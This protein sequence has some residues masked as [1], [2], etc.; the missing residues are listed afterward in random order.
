MTSVEGRHNT[1]TIPEEIFS[2]EEFVNS[3]SHGVA[4]GMSMAG[5]ALMIVVA[6][7][8]GG[9]IEIVSAVVYGTTLVMLFGAS[10]LYHGMRTPALK[11]TFRVVDHSA[12]YLLIAG[13]YTPL[14]LVTLSGE[15]GWVIFGGVWAMALIGVFY[16]IFW[17][18][19]FKGLGLG[20]YLVMGWMIVLAAKPLWESWEVGGLVLMAVG[21]LLYTGGVVFYLWERLFFNHAIWHLFVLAAAICHYLA[22]LLYVLM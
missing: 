9:T 2:A 11:R 1:E 7:I 14:A 22:I 10:T 18:G 6:A 4:L 19:R 8:N 21:G 5:M 16:K 13:T 17:F 12:I 20:L 15:L 3:L